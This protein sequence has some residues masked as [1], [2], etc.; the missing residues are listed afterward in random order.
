MAEGPLAV[1]EHSEGDAPTSL[2]TRRCCLRLALQ[3]LLFQIPA[4]EVTLD[5]YIVP[6]L[7]GNVEV[8]AQGRMRCFLAVYVLGA[9][10]H[11]IQEFLQHELEG[12]ALAD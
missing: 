1:C 3:E 9:C 11:L 5:G 7:V 6:A 2:S 12:W 4:A 10:V 8:V